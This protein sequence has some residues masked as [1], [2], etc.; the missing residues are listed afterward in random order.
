[1]SQATDDL[2]AAARVLKERMEQRAAK[3]KAI[4]ELAIERRKN[5][6]CKTTA[7]RCKS[8]MRELSITVIDFT[9]PILDVIRALDR[10]DKEVL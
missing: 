1:M 9:D 8:R 5:P 2:V 6:Q 3:T 7:R 10:Y 4:Q